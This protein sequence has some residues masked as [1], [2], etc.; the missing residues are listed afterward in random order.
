MTFT[1]E[2]FAERFHG[3]LIEP[4]LLFGYSPFKEPR[5]L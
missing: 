2:N 4:A 3:R 1:L 5:W